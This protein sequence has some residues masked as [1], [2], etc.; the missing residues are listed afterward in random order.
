MR[1]PSYIYVISFYKGDFS[2]NNNQISISDEAFIELLNDIK[3]FDAEQFKKETLQILSE[4]LSKPKWKQDYVTIHEC[5]ITLS[6]G[7]G[8]DYNNEYE[9]KA[10]KQQ[11]N[12]RKINRAK[13]NIIRKVAMF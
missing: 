11:Q 2:L 9:K 5:Y 6:E 3:N 13:K 4:E 10:E 12:L 7:F 1:F 8:Y